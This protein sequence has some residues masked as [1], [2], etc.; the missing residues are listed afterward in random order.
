[1]RIILGVAAAAAICAMSA[2]LAV[3][4]TTHYAGGPIREGNMCWVNYSSD[5]GYGFWKACAPAASMMHHK[6]K[7]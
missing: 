6:K 3:A 4:E 1:M 2:N 5:L 7:M